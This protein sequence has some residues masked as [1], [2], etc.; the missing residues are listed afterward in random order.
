MEFMSNIGSTSDVLRPSLFELIAQDKLNV[1]FRPA[2]RY[3]VTVYAQRYPRYLLKVLKYYDELYAVL[4]LFI[5][6]HYLYDWNASFSE[7]FYGLRRL[8]K[9]VPASN[10]EL[11]SS[12]NGPS[13]QDLSRGNSLTSVDIWNSLLILVGVPYV[14]NKLDELYDS[15]T[16][17]A[18]ARLLGDDIF[19]DEEETDEEL[20]SDENSSWISRLR[21]ARHHL[22]KKLTR[23]SRNMFVA[24]YPHFHLVYHLVP[25]TYHIAYLFERTDFHIP[26]NHFAALTMRRMGADDY[27]AHQA[28]K[29]LER[30]AAAKAAASMKRGGKLAYVGWMVLRYGLDALKVTLPMAVFLLKFLE[31]W[32]GSEN[33]QKS[34]GMYMGPLPNPPAPLKVR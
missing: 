7:S 26:T 25:L 10:V 3:M 13:N 30:S 32:Y 6:R 29:N 15:L 24:F 28:R 5:E 23:S 18:A 2:L 21:E 8:K 4:M 16:G 22:G 34:A 20:G 17:G 27:K 11:D 14:K 33:R 1:L 9:E 31:W 12:G 19:D